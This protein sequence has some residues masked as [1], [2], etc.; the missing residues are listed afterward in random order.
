L[1]K[2]LNAVYH[3]HLMKPE[4]L[5]ELLTK[6]QLR[7]KDEVFLDQ[8]M[9]SAEASSS[10]ATAMEQ[11]LYELIRAAISEPLV[12]TDQTASDNLQAFSDFDEK[13]PLLLSKVPAWM[14]PD[15]VKGRQALQ[16]KCQGPAFVQGLFKMI[17]H[18]NRVAQEE[19]EQAKAAVVLL[20]VTIWATCPW[21]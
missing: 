14:F 1:A 2:E 19:L 11:P 21:S 10:T 12:A 17:Q 18:R 20:V 6:A 5:N 16:K 8:T 13:F 9:F 4:G 7:L 3:E 15:A